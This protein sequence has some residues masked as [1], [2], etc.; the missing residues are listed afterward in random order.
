MNFT[1]TRLKNALTELDFIVEHSTNLT[2]NDWSSSGIGLESTPFADD[3]TRQS[4]TVAVPIAASDS[5]RFV[6]LKVVRK[7]P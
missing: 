6:R 4:V 5:R 2:Q 7:Q 1:Y 3:G